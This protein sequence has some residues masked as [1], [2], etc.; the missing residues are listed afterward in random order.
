[1]CT[2]SSDDII[3]AAS[4]AEVCPFPKTSLPRIFEEEPTLARLFFYV[5]GRDCVISKGLICAAVLF[6]ATE[7]LAY[8]LLLLKTRLESD[9]NQN[10]GS[11][12]YI[13]LTQ[14]EIGQTISLSQ[15]QVNRSM[16][17]LREKGLISVKRSVVNI[18]NESGLVK[19]AH[20]EKNRYKISKESLKGN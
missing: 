10:A 9:K 3:T 11:E 20:F 19:L 16:R 17:E 5:L 12:F 15:H 1:M 13:K 18:L 8:F 7:R 6:P 14:E 4:S 2:R